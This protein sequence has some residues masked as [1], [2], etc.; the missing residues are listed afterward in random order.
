MEL[1][2]DSLDG[3]ITK[4]WYQWALTATG[5]PV[6]PRLPTINLH[7]VNPC[8]AINLTVSVLIMTKHGSKAYH[9]CTHALEEHL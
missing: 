9:A 1:V 8:P 3:A 6:H 7:Q 4:V 5:R 2:V